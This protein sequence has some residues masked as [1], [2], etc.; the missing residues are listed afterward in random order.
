MKPL[1]SSI[2]IPYAQHSTSYGK[3]LR[4]VSLSSKIDITQPVS[5]FFFFSSED[6]SCGPAF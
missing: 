2:P 3:L 1:G 6:K 4:I 5:P